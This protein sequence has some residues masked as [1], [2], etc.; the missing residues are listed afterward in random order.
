ML[1]IRANPD[2]MQRQKRTGPVSKTKSAARSGK[3][4]CVLRVRWRGE[5]VGGR[6]D[7][8]SAAWWEKR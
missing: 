6:S 8:H 7:H 4:R 1:W 2:V 3:G 5:I